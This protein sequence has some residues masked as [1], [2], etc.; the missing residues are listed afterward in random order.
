MKNK[1]QVVLA[2]RHQSNIILCSAFL[3]KYNM[4]VTTS[5]TLKELKAILP[6]LSVDILLYELDQ[7]DGDSMAFLQT[8]DLQRSMGI[9][10]FTQQ[11][12]AIDKY[13]A[14]ETCA[15]D[16]IQKPCHF[17]EVVARIRAVHRRIQHN[18][19]KEVFTVYCKDFV[20]NHLLRTVTLNSGQKVDLT[21]YEFDV[22]NTLVS[23]KMRPLSRQQIIN[24]GFNNWQA[25]TITPRNI[26]SII[27]RLRKKLAGKHSIKSIYGVGYMFREA[28]SEGLSSGKT[29]EGIVGRGL[30][31]LEES[32]Q[33]LVIKVSRQRFS[34]KELG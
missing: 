16:F 28:D 31:H 29:I 24:I 13:I 25:E 11:I 32:I 14:L 22:L 23:R 7:S 8:L 6:T 17:R 26:D 9:I 2:D 34:T 19:E 1:L 15:D 5:K 12:D 33:Q 27:Y 30:I 21:Q 3:Q 18:K 20:I 4:Q 10:V